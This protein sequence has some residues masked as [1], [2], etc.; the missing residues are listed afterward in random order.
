MIF[1]MRIL[2]SQIKLN[3]VMLIGMT[4]SVF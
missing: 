1:V 3:W 4:C 2:S